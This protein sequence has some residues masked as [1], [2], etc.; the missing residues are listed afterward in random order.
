MDENNLSAAEQPVT[1]G[2]VQ[3]QWNTPVT[4]VLETTS[5]E[6]KAATVYAVMQREILSWGRW[7]LFF[8]VLQIVMGGFLNASWGITLL[9]VGALSF[10]FRDASLF[11]L[12]AVTLLWAGVS[13]LSVGSV[14]W[15]GFA[16]LQFI[17]VLSI[18]RQYFR[19]RRA[20]R[21]MFAYLPQKEQAIIQ[22]AA[23]FFPWAGV[24]LSS[25]A[26]GGIIVILADIWFLKLFYP[27]YP[28]VVEFLL[29][30]MIDFAVVGLGLNLGA[31]LSG[32][33]YKILAAI[34]FLASLLVLGGWIVLLIL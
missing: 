32:F 9:A 24:L 14:Q 30:L 23:T 4:P 18:F 17:L 27:L 2:N 8:G 16:V 31:L 34:G 26:F 3:E 29:G 10:Y 28:Q 20:Q 25:V 33:G 6:T 11:V 15:I 21:E 22:R 5:Q 19:F 12:Y 7:Q 1:A 13:N